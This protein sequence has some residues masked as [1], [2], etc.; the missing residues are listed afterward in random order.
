MRTIKQNSQSS[1]FLVSSS[2][3]V[4]SSFGG[5]SLLRIFFILRMFLPNFFKNFNKSLPRLPSLPD[6]HQKFQLR[7]PAPSDKKNI[8]P[9]PPGGVLF[10]PFPFHHPQ[11]CYS[12]KN[13]TTLPGPSEHRGGHTPPSP[14]TAAGDK[15]LNLVSPDPCQRTCL[16]FGSA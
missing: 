2:P 1:V 14:H 6:R 9:P 7:P 15:Q 5:F 11:I 16:F 13:N 4:F 10:F 8:L 12:S 3:S